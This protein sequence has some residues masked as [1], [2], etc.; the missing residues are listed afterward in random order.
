MENWGDWQ[1]GLLLFF[2]SALMLVIAVL[3]GG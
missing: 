1:T 3:L 2:I